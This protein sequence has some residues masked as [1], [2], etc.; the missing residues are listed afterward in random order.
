MPPYGVHELLLKEREGSGA[1]SSTTDS[2]DP[3][4]QAALIRAVRDGD[5]ERV[6]YLLSRRNISLLLRD[7]HDSTPLYY[8]ALCGEFDICKLLLESGAKADE[9]VRRRTS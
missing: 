1:A 2:V 3:S 6:R 9:K 8:A 7:E 5:L 4:A